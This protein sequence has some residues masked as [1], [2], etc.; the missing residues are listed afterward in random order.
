MSLPGARP[1]GETRAWVFICRLA[2]LPGLGHSSPP[3]MRCS[4]CTQASR[5]PLQGTLRISPRLALPCPELWLPPGLLTPAP[6]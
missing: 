5:R 6:F 1:C 2:R 3:W 4:L